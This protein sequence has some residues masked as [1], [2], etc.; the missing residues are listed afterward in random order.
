[1]QYFRAL[2]SITFLGILFLGCAKGPKPEE[3][4]PQIRGWIEDFFEVQKV[5]I[6]G[7][8]IEKGGTAKIRAKAAIKLRQPLDPVSSQVFG[9]KE[10]PVEVSTTKE[11]I[12]IFKKYDTGWK[13]EE[14]PLSQDEKSA[15]ISKRRGLKV[16]FSSV[17][18]GVLLGLRSETRRRE[19]LALCETDE[20]NKDYR[21]RTLWIA[22]GENSIIMSEMG[23]IVIPRGQNF[24]RVGVTRK[25]RG[26]WTEDFVW[27]TQLGKNPVVG[28]ISSNMAS[29]EGNTR[30][31]VLFVGND[32]VSVDEGSDGIGGAHP[33][34]TNSLK[35]LSIDNPRAEE[36]I[37]L[38]TIFGS[39]TVASFQNSARRYRETA[40]DRDCLEEQASENSWGIIRKNR[41]WTV[42]G[43]IG[44]TSEACRGIYGDFE[45]L[46]TPPNSIVSHDRLRYSWRVIK[47][48]INE[49]VDA[50]SSPSGDV[51]IVLTRSELF[52][53]FPKNHDIGNPAKKINLK[54]NESVVMSQWATGSYV[55]KWTRLM[56]R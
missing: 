54:N 22:P 10:K 34:H 27:A 31:R 48:R 6:T 2:I 8:R 38:S 13:L 26:D 24:W 9:L 25:T 52:V 39:Q 35:F 49:A 28:N 11:L 12:F 21:Y 5:E 33:W 15:I 14:G 30:K 41:K 7:T 56:R 36:G 29:C 3:I 32:Y 18:S 42:I 17:S 43:R 47:E 20:A 16:S 37:T 55:K 50:L 4:A 1:M 40:K 46:L 45:T 51:L 19:K 23:N 53:F 44:Y